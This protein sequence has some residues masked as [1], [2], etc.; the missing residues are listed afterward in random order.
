MNSKPDSSP[1][2][3]ALTA[4]AGAVVIGGTNFVAVRFSNRELEPFWGA[5]ARFVLAAIL[6]GG[7]IAITRTSLPQTRGG[8]VRATA[9]GLLAI[10]GTYGLLYWGMREVPAGVASVVMASAPLLTLCL[11]IAH[12]ME[13]FA[14][15]ALVGA[16]LALAGTGVMLIQPSEFEFS[17]LSLLA[18]VAGTVCAAE[19]VIVAKRSPDVSPYVMNGVGM[20]IGG[21][22]LLAVSSVTGE[23][24]MI[25]NNFSTQLAVSYL[26]VFSL[27]L[28]LLFFVVV[29][30]WVAS[31]TSYIFVLFPVVAVALGAL[32]ADEPVTRSTVAG[33]G[34]VMAAV[35]VGALR[36]PT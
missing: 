34:L 24:W 1:D 17:L 30:R 32:I 36:K 3:I 20:L 8:W 7:L 33:A 6:F 4:F 28:F 9:Y 12:R 5:G 13:P 10:A 11:A 16:L 25:P 15:R 23:T 26:I 18:V 21:V 2:H 31:A 22:V 27:P 29:R 14:A 19:S 35:Y